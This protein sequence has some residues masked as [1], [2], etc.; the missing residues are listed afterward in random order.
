MIG[1][2]V[3]SDAEFAAFRRFLYEKGRTCPHWDE[4]RPCP[5]S[6]LVGETRRGGRRFRCDECGEKW[7]LT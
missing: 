6:R 2:P 5:H 4:P 3:P 1:R 7:R